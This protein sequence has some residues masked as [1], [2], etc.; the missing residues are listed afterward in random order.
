MPAM[1][2]AASKA[3]MVVGIRHTRSAISVGMSSVEVE[4]P[5]H[6]VKRGG[7]DQEDDR[8]R[9]QNDRQRDLIGRLLADC[10]LDQGDHPVE[11]ALARPRP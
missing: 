2:M 4:V 8:E 10:P 6:R 9:G 7:D 11:E 3:P 1:P 5:G